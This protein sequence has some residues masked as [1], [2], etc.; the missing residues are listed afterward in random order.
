M[1]FDEVERAVE[2]ILQLLAQYE[3]SAQKAQEERR[4]FEEKW[5]EERRELGLTI[6]RFAEGSLGLVEVERQNLS[7][8]ARVEES[9]VVIT[10]LLQKQENRLDQ[11]SDRLDRLGG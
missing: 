2:Y 11:H 10:Q 9:I 4:E 6:Q 8:V 1:T 5:K 7:R 3:I